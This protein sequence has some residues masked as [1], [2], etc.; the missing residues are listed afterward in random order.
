ML[1]GLLACQVHQILAIIS[2]NPE[3]IF[4][5]T[6]CFLLTTFYSEIIFLL[7]FYGLAT[8][9]P[10]VMKLY[11]RNIEINLNNFILVP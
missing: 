7:I 2:E 4:S 9:T 5:F 11:Y 6:A 8:L 10:R 3:A 1:Y